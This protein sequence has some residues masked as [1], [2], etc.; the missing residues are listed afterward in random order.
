[1]NY[2]RENKGN[3]FEENIILK[4]GYKWLS[5]IKGEA[6]ASFKTKNEAEEHLNYANK[7][8]RGLNE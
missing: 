2:I 6:E 5:H 4:Q 8:E 1:M 3:T 7:F